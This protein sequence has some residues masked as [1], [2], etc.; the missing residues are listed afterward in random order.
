MIGLQG[1]SQII[2]NDERLEIL[3]YDTAEIRWVD[4]LPVRG[5][6][7]RLW[8]EC[9]IQPLNARDLLIVPEGDRHKEQYNLWT[10]KCDPSRVLVNDTVI[11]DGKYFQVQGTENWGSYTKA[12]IMLIDAGPRATQ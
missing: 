12:R 8:V 4:G 1:P 3:R 7:T 10:Q 11:R 2:N 5:P 6:E 9:N